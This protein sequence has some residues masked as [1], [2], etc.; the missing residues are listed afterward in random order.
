MHIS[1]LQKKKPIYCDLMSTKITLN[2][3]KNIKIETYVRLYG[4][5]VL[6]GG[7]SNSVYSIYK[8]DK[9]KDDYMTG[10]GGFIY[11]SFKILWAPVIVPSYIVAK[12]CQKKQEI[13]KTN[14]HN[15]F[16]N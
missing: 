1:F 5:M 8:N 10:I 13:I 14:Q 4:F 12:V 7:I 2:N 3:L 15:F 6:G 11:G 16:R 9:T